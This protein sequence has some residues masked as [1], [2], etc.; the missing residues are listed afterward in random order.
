MCAR[1]RNLALGQAPIRAKAPLAW[2]IRHGGVSDVTDP[3]LAAAAG[4][5]AC[6]SAA[7]RRY[8]ALSFLFVHVLACHGG[9]S[10]RMAHLRPHPLLQR[11]P[12]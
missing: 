5:A 6:A 3:P 4:R 7:L 12:A 2:C 9:V 11:V 8:L 1:G 10:E